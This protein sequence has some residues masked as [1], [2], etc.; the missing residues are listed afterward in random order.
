MIKELFI[1]YR[2]LIIY[3]IIGG[4]CA[5]LDFIVYSAL[6]FVL[7]FL[8]V[9]IIS[10][11]CGIFCSFYLNRKYNFKVEDKTFRRFLIFYAVGLSGLAVSEILLGFMVNKIGV[12]KLIA[13]LLTIVVVALL[14][15]V[16]N[17]FITFKTKSDG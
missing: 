3:G 10:T 2:D 15:F 7:P 11:H 14:Q 12:E 8:V 13:K 1:K 4:F 9:N 17:K 6:C 5:I 16:L